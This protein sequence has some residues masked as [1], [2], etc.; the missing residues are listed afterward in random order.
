MQLHVL[1]KVAKTLKCAIGNATTKLYVVLF[2]FP[3]NK[4]VHCWTH[5]LPEV[6]MPS[7]VDCDPPKRFG[8][9]GF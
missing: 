9:P 6:T 7:V 1:I 2:V 3:V 5:Q 4:A 8:L